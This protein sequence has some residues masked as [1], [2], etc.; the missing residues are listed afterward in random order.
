MRSLKIRIYKGENPKPDT[1]ITIPI[2]ILRFAHKIM[3]RQAT[4]TIQSYGINLN[5]IV[6]LSMQEDIEGTLV[7][8]E[9]HA[10]NEKVII[11]VE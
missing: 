10:K 3:P 11:S 4:E 8:I 7:E 2:G 9:R 6:E 5:E 1:T